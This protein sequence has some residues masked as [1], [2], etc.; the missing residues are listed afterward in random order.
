MFTMM[1]PLFHYNESEPLDPYIYRCYSNQFFIDSSKAAVFA[2]V[3]TSRTNKEL[4]DE[5]EVEPF[6]EPNSDNAEEWLDYKKKILEM[7]QNL[8]ERKKLTFLKDIK[9]L[10]FEIPFAEKEDY[11]N[12]FAMHDRNIEQDVL[13]RTEKLRDER[14]KSKEIEMK[15]TYGK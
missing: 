12:Y 15:K 9:M 13:K 1:N 7:V 3:Y 8:I 2:G 6:S 10:W 5:A 11:L 4:F 14:K